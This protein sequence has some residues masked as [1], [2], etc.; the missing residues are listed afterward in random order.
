MKPSGLTLVLYIVF[1]KKKR[2]KMMRKKLKVADMLSLRSLL[3]NLMNV[4]IAFSFKQVGT[5]EVFTR[6]QENVTISLSSRLQVYGLI[7]FV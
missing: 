6:I 3:S 7:L 1:L 2:C 5:S 4:S